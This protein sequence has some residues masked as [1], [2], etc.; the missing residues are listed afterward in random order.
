MAQNGIRGVS[1]GE[2]LSHVLESLD[3]N[4]WHRAAEAVS[5]LSFPKK[6]L[7]RVDQL[8]RKNR[9]GK[10]SKGEHKELETYLRVGNFLGLMRARAERELA[11]AV[12]A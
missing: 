9:S 5:K 4:S 12:A 3:K 10:I 1:E 6:D 11:A 8:L 7:D 2:I